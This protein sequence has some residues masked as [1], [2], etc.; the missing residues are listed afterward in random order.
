MSERVCVLVH[1][2]VSLCAHGCLDICGCVL[3]VLVHM[4]VRD[5]RVRVYS[6]CV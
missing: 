5:V 1:V 3:F 2:C 4:G 6:L